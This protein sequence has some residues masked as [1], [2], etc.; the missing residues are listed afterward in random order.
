M[1]WRC[2]TRPDAKCTPTTFL[3]IFSRPLLH[4]PAAFGS[5]LVEWGSLSTQPCCSYE[6]FMAACLLSDNQHRLSLASCSTRLH[7]A[8]M[9][10][11]LYRTL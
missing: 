7:G 6:H 4:S 10:P 2:A 1:R 9:E 8:V 5:A 11:V 3:Q